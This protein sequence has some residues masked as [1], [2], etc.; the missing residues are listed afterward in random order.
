LSY[1]SSKTGTAT[2]KNGDQKMTQSAKQFRSTVI[3]FIE[4][5]KIESDSLYNFV[6]ESAEECTSPRGIMTKIFVEEFEEVEDH[7]EYGIVTVQKWGLFNWLAGQKKTLVE[8]YDTLEEAEDEWLTRIYKYDFLEDDQRDT[9]YYA[10][11]EEAQKELSE[12]NQ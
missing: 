10:S 9:M 8:S 1:T 12:R 4:N 6:I 2:C 3:F 11:I 7:E 5:G